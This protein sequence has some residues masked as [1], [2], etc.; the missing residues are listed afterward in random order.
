M[1]S[2]WRYLKRNCPVCNGSRSD[3]RENL[4]NN[5]I[6]CRHDVT[7]APGY[8]C[9]GED[10]LG[11]FLWAVD[12]GEE[13]NSDE[14]EQ[15]RQQRA[16]QRGKRLQEEAARCARLLPIEQRDRAIRK[17]SQQ[18]GLSRAHRQHLQQQRGLS[19]TEID[20][21]C[22]FTIAPYQDVIYI[23]PQLAGIDLWGHQLTV[24]KPGIGC[25]IFDVFERIIGFQI[26][27]DNATENKY[28]WPTSRSRFR[29]N[30]PTAH[31]PNGELPIAVWRPLGDIQRSSIGITEG[32]NPKPYIVATRL[33]Q[34]CLGAAGGNFASSPQQFKESLD[35]LSTQ[36]NTKT[37]DF[38]PDAGAIHNSHVLRHYRATFK[39]VQQWGY[40]LRV[41][42][43][44]Q[45][46]KEEHLDIDDLLI[47]GRSDEIQ[48]ITVAQ[49]ERLIRQP[50]IK[51]HG[52]KDLLGWFPKLKNR[53]AQLSQ[54]RSRYGFAP[55]ETVETE[56]TPATPTRTITYQDGQRL[57]AWS[58]TLNQGVRFICDSSATGTGKSYD[59]GLTNNPL[60]DSRRILFLSSEHRNPTVPTLKTW[61]D[62]EA[63][64]DGLT[65][66]SFGRKRRAKSDELPRIRSNC[67][68]NL[69]INALR[70]LN[71]DDA[72]T[73]ICQTCP[74]LQ[75]CQGGYEFGFLHQRRVALKSNRFRAHP[76]S[77]PDP[78]EYDYTKVVLLWDEW[79]TLLRTTRT[80][81]VTQKD[82]DQLIV[83]LVTKKDGVYSVLEDLLQAL[84]A[85]L[86]GEIPAPSRYGWNHAGVLELLP[87]LPQDLDYNTISQAI[88]PDLRKLDPKA[89]HEAGIAKLS[90]SAHH[91]RT[92]SDATVAQTIR[93]QF[94][95]QWLVPF[96]T[97]LNGAAGHLRI[98]YGVLSITLPDDRLVRIAKA[99]KGNIFLDATGDLTEL[100]QLLGVSPTEIISLKQGVTPRSNLEVIQVATL[101]RL[102]NSDRS[103]CLQQRIDAII[104]TIQEKD[105]TAKVIDFKAFAPDGALRWWVES[106]GVNDLES[107][108]TL[109]LVGTPCRSLS[110]LEAEFTLRYGRT[111]QPGTV[112]V[113][114]PIRVGRGN[115]LLSSL[116]LSEVEALS[117]AQSGSISSSERPP[118][119]LPSTEPPYL[120]M[121]VS[122][123]PEF[124]AFVRRCILADIH[125]AIGRLRAHRRPHQ[126][127][128]I[129]FLG[130]YPLDIPVT[131]TLASSIT[132]DAASKTERVEMAIKAAVEQL[133]QTG[134]KITQRAIAT[135]TG[136]SQQ[137]ISRFRDLLKMLIGS[138]NS[139]MSKTQPAPEQEEELRW[140]ATVY[141]PLVTSDSPDEILETMATTW[142]VYSY[143]DF[144]WLW[145]A[146]PG[147]TQITILAKLMLTLP[148][149][150]LRELAQMTGG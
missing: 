128:R 114:Y 85:L 112:K 76:E 109:I 96:L 108:Q 134:E 142:S 8:K 133:K 48:Y 47:A 129:Y 143:S 107:T 64:H 66:D 44:G 4:Q 84:R 43:W 28:K 59:C 24:S 79:S 150:Q 124:R 75:A 99:A 40:Q 102:G 19:D 131:L 105:P 101:G 49:F 60:F 98:A 127:L 81:E 70:S 50:H 62:L 61:T 27:F 139:K 74:H 135:I 23:N 97:V 148:E 10:I 145:D 149:R 22:Y 25:P 11:F 119:S 92:N 45:T 1:A 58:R 15:L 103:D 144:Q 35:I 100:A 121:N 17:L 32:V 14:W 138:S 125:Q 116:A 54:R 122:A 57:D 82:I 68:R 126:K 118:N 51:L 77:L 39:L 73:V 120:E 137:H 111:P 5:L 117:D 80:L 42:W 88:K 110:H 104:K 147:L 86:T 31:L 71:I 63:R 106:R 91:N 136:Y 46:T 16:A 12:D 29:P 26:R 18:V 113:K 2:T 93:E 132:P 72:D 130:D 3:C 53:L 13:R 90:A 67:S 38:Y 95:L 34:P 65:I 36:L 21:A 6:H 140:L 89:K 146:I 87:Q 7:T 69:T 55:V 30:G 56:P 41:A 37:I 52:F 78:A 94:L 123:D 83:H 20:H 115:K 141:L 33:D 9:V